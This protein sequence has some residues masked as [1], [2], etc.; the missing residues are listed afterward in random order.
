MAIG[1]ALS[2]YDYHCKTWKMISI[3]KR[4]KIIESSERYLESDNHLKYPIYR[5]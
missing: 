2:V 1:N 5:Q 3:S 4:R